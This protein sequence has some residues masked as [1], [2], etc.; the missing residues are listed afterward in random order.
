MYYAYLNKDSLSSFCTQKPPSVPKEKTEH[1][2]K[3]SIST[4]V[5]E[6]C[7]FNLQTLPKIIKFAAAVA[8]FFFLQEDG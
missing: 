5:F 6:Q 8:I 3:L 2:F 1:S 4:G 7:I